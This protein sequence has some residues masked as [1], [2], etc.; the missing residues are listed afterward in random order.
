MNDIAWKT[1]NR[2]FNE[3]PNILLKHHL[4]SYNDFFSKGIINIFKNTNPI[5]LLEELDEETQQ[6]K[7]ECNLYF[8]GKEGNKIYYGKPIIYDRNSDGEDRE[9]YMFPNEARLRNM[10]YAF[11]IHYDIYAEFT[12]LIE[13]NSGETGMN[14]FHPPEI[15]PIT[16]EKIYLGKF[17]IMLQSDLC[18]LKNCTHQQN[19]KRSRL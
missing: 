13:N 9:H 8:G 14:K 16:L 4:D 7:Y 1:I 6:Y 11:T 2:Y 18:I 3:N 10:T 17:P 15:I 19:S 5:R 12:L